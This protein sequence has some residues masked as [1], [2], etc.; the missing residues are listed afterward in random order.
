MESHSVRE[1]TELIPRT[2]A[3]INNID[4][5]S[6]SLNPTAKTEYWQQVQSEMPHV[7]FKFSDDI[8]DN[9]LTHDQ[10][11]D[12]ALKCD[13]PNCWVEGAKEDYPQDS[14]M[15]VTKVF[16]EWWGRCHLNIG[17]KIQLIQVAFVYMGKLAV[18]NRIMG[19][20]PGLKILL[21][22]ARLNITPALTHGDG[23]ICLNKTV[24]LK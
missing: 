6:T 2:N 21:E 17:K 1:V 10:L 3:N 16:F 15:I 24:V 4:S 20:Y 13:I 11:H 14:E 5:E 19:K 18:F 23:V 7:I 22:Y 8:I 9:I 12:F